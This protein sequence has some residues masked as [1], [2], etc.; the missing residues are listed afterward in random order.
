KYK[1]ELEKAVSDEWLTD[2]EKASLSAL[3]VKLRISDGRLDDIRRDL[4]GRTLQRV[5]DEAIAD[6]QLS[7]DEEQRLERLAGNLGIRATYDSETKALMDR[8]RLF[9]QMRQGQ[10]PTLDVPIHLQKSETCHWQSPGSLHEMRRVTTGVRYA[11]PTA[12]IRIMK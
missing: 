9:W 12:R 2:D 7:P 1:R 4:L 3:A 11:G 6:H 5:F 10:L 8:Y